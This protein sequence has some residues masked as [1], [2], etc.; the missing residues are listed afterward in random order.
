MKLASPFVDIGLATN[1]LEPTLKFWR[2]E[3]QLPLERVMPVR[4]GMDQH[5]Y[6]A[7]GAVVKINHHASPLNDEP[8]SGYLELLIANEDASHARALTDPGGA[9]VSLVPKGQDGVTQVGVRLGV[10]DLDAHRRF[11]AE[12]LRLPE[13]RAGAFRAGETLF[14]L[15]QDASAPTDPSMDAAGWRYITFQVADLLADYPAIL[16]GG[17]REARAP[18]TFGGTTR[19]ALLRDPDGNWIEVVQRAAPGETFE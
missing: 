17:G 9:R 12:G 11:Y 18:F 13:E 4:P 3:M 16:A 2:D 7:R 14:L 19:V 8:P 5:R 15:E 1:A 6:V 10:R